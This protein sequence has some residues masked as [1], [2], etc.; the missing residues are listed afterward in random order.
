MK[1]NIDLE[2]FLLPKAES[3]DI[4]AI[5]ML[6][7]DYDKK[8][9]RWQDEPQVGES[10]SFEEFLANM[11]KKP[12]EKFSAE[13]FKWFL[14]GAELGDAE[15]M[16]EVGH[17]LYDG[18][19]C[20]KD[21]TAA[22]GWHLKA[23]QAGLVSAMK[24]T[25]HMYGGLCV[26]RNDTE[27]FRWYMAAAKTGDQ[28]SIGEIVKRYALG[29]GV[30]K[31]LDEAENWLDELDD[32]HYRQTLHELSNGGED[33]MMWLERLVEIEDP[34]AL[35][36]KADLLATGDGVEQNFLAALKLY[37]KVGMTEN[38]NYNPDIFWE[39]LVQ[40]GNIYY[41]GERGVEQSYRK[42][43]KFYS[44]AVNDDYIKAHIHLG[45]MYYYGLGCQRDFEKAFE[46]FY[47]A[48]TNREKFMFVDRINS[49][50]REYVGRMYEHGEFVE[51]NLA[52]AYR[53][54]ELAAEDSRNEEMMLKV[55]DAYLYGNAAVEKNVDK[56]LKLL[57]D[58]GQ[59]DTHEFFFEANLQL[60]WIYELGEHG[61]EQN[62]AKADEYWAK[63]PPE[64]KPARVSC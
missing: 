55:A 31:N 12:D 22:F 17:R 19:G 18:I 29:T 30:E 39:A 63:L 20:E 26:E 28:Q 64:C 43:R 53:W 35:K 44:A 33:S 48:A 6:A 23:A 61:V 4:I 38:L 2:K 60:A 52:E 16:H 14:R 36:Q 9:G 56:A 3:G 10:I 59:Y 50:A 62:F 47:A 37:K 41:A 24:V 40:A 11:D 42:A 8:S 54:Y 49:V 34:A 27:A 58:V 13:A 5:K 25:A 7:H 57:E 51:E 46:L 45:K 32:E 15:C 1:K 21:G